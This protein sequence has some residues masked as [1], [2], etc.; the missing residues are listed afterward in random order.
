MY[1]HGP[2]FSTA[3]IHMMSAETVALITISQTYNKTPEKKDEGNYL[4]KTPPNSPSHPPP[5]NGPLTIEK[6][7]FDIILR[8]P[9]STI[10]KK[11]SIQ[12]LELLNFIMLLNI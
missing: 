5:S 6:P 4:D 11:N 12:L 7:S 2:S 1:S 3:E 8:P 9:K 10:C